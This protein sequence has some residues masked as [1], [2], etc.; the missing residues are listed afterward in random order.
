[1]GKLRWVPWGNREL[2]WVLE[3][4]SDMTRFSLWRK[5]L[6]YGRR[7]LLRYT[8]A[9]TYKHSSGHTCTQQNSHLYK[10]IHSPTQ[11]SSNLCVH[12]QAFLLKQAS[13]LSI[14]SGTDN[15]C[16]HWCTTLAPLTQALAGKH[17]STGQP[18][19]A[20]HRC[21][22]AEPPPTKLWPSGSSQGST[23]PSRRFPPSG[24]HRAHRSSRC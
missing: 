9:H 6:R 11:T 2:W 19:P 21:T 7:T 20:G 16:S 24:D 15:S 3:H 4:E 10:P 13:T 23:P 1:M 17:R 14:H 22:L 18:P 8:R 5:D 12:T